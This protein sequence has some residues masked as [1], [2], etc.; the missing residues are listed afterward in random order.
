MTAALPFMSG[1]R[2]IERFSC[3]MRTA[4]RLP[5]GSPREAPGRMGLGS[6]IFAET[7][8]GRRRPEITRRARSAKTEGRT[9]CDC[10]IFIPAQA[11]L[12]GPQRNAERRGADS[13]RSRE[14][15]FG[16]G[17]IQFL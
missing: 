14:L 9:L 8:E 13:A 16:A 5:N 12:G 6:A 7:G 17:R 4:F 1:R 15:E 2:S 11:N 3:S 10:S